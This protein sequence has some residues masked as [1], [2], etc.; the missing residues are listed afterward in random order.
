VV[1]IVGHLILRVLVP[2]WA[3]NG[4]T[5]AGGLEEQ[6]VHVVGLS[7]SLVDSSES[8]ALNAGRLE[9]WLAHLEAFL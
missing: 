1:K 9:P 3:H 6:V 4:Q 8:S 7:V 5:S 2:H